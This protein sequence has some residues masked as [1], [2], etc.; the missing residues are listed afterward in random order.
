MISQDKFYKMF[1]DYSVTLY[2]LEGRVNNHNYSGST[3]GDLDYKI[4]STKA[5][6]EHM[7]DLSVDN[8]E[9]VDY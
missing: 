2:L 9:E 1:Y 7:I 5:M 6:I 4:Y 3:K 8:D